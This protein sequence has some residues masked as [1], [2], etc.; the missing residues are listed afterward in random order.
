MC[1]KRIHSNA[2]N[3]Q[4]MLQNKIVI[5]IYPVPNKPIRPLAPFCSNVKSALKTPLANQLKLL[6]GI[7]NAKTSIWTS[8]TWKTPLQV[9]R[10]TEIKVYF[11][12]IPANTLLPNQLEN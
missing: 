9:T 7:E 12:F 11:Q 5:K 4:K 2:S 3:M 1:C 6:L 8:Q 10:M